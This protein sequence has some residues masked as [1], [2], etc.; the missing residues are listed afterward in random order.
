VNSVQFIASVITQPEARYFESGSQVCEFRASISQGKNN[1]G[2]W[3][4]SIVQTVKCWGKTAEIATDSLRKGCKVAV[5]G[6]MT[7]EEWTDRQSGEKRTKNF[8]TASRVMLVDIPSR[9]SA[10][11]PSGGGSSGFDDDDVPF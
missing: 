3:K 6:R 7:A 4:P 2:T 9:G 11:T 1:D 10:S 5:E 8:I